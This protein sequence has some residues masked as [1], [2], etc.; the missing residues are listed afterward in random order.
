MS[1]FLKQHG[2]SFND[3]TAS[4]GIVKLKI[5]PGLG[6]VSAKVHHFRPN[7]CD[8]RFHIS[9][10]TTRAFNLLPRKETSSRSY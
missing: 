3:F 4:P 8:S 6:P 1:C 2:N 10:T 7:K 9:K 5:A